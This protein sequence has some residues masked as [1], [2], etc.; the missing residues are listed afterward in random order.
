[1]H[2]HTP[3]ASMQPWGVT[4]GSISGPFLKQVWRRVACATA[5]FPQ[6][7]SQKWSNFGPF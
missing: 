6:K 1:M 5:V 2:H 3:P 4:W 7:G